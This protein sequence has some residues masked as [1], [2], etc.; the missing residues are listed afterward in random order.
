MLEQPPHIR[1][2]APNMTATTQADV[3]LRHLRTFAATDGAGGPTD[4]PLLGQVA[5]GRETASEALVRRHARLV[6]AVCRRVLRNEA[7]ADDAFQATFLIL[8]RKAREVG[9]Q[10]SV[11]AWLHRVAYHAA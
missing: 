1:Q 6:L 8:A 5:P 9:R 7:D 10:G 2:R 11:A 3:I 4:R